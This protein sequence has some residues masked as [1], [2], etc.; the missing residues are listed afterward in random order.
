MSDFDVIVIG[1]GPAGENVAGRCADAWLSTITT[2]KDL[3]GGGCAY[4]R[5]VPPKT[6]PP[7]CGAP[8]AAHP[9]LRLTVRRPDPGTFTRSVRWSCAHTAQKLDPP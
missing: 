1:A 9:L 2:A 5:R 4:W 8:P 3:V 7:P 6:P